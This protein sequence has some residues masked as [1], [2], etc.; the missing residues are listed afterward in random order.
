[1]AIR[2]ASIEFREV[3]K[4]YGDFVALES[5]S[6]DVAP[7][8]F[9]TLLG[10]SG[11]GKTTALNSLAG[12]VDINQGD[13]L[14]DGVSIA[15]MPT[16][17]RNIGM[18]FQNYSLFPHRNVLANV[19]FP[20]EMRGVA[21]SEILNRSMKALEMV[22]LDGLAKRMPHELSGGQ[23]QRVAFARAVVFEPRVLLM[24]EPL[25]ALDLKL[26]EALQIEIK[27]YQREIGCTVIYVTHDQGEALALSDRL[28]VM[29]KGAIR[30]LGTPEDLYDRP[31]SR[32]VAEFIGSNNILKIRG[33]TEEGVLVEGLGVVRIPAM[34]GHAGGFVA[35]RPE[36]IRRSSGENWPVTVRQAVFFGDAVR[37][38]V[39][40]KDGT[41]F[42]FV[43]SRQPGTEISAPGASIGIAFDEDNITLLPA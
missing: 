25:G 6:M 37:Y 5:F 16:E 41:T 24:D 33:Q 7:G 35:L 10:P 34:S 3:R 29:E 1:M 26:R 30:Q 36:H 32:F 2:G 27:Q 19:A 38:V 15:R 9:M 22:R 4:T 12:F 17:K 42:S 13:I 21:K 31:N 8:E 23:K 11:S 14:I 43:E 39:E 18:V 28:A 40:A 20:L